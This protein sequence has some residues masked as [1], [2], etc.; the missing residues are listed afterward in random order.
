M[1]W[2]GLVGSEVIRGVES[3]REGTT[4]AFWDLIPE[5]GADLGFGRILWH[6]S[7]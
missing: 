2:R 1:L 6:G 5:S 3:P 4:T 7:G